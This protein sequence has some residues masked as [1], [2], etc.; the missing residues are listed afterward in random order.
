MKCRS[1]RPTAWLQS[2]C[3]AMIRS[4]VRSVVRSPVRGLFGRFLTPAL[5]QL[6]AY[7]A[8]DAWDFV[9]NSY[10]RAGTV[11]PSGLTVTRASDGYA[12]TASG[13]LVNFGSNVLRRTDRGVLV[14]GA[15]TN[16]LLRS[17]EFDDA[18]WATNDVSKSANQIIA[19]DGTLTGDLVADNSTLTFH[20][21]FQALSFTS[22]D[23]HTFSCFF[24]N[25]T[26]RYVQMAFFI[27]SHGNN[28]FAN[29]DLQAGVVGTVGASASATMT[30]LANGWYRCTIRATATATASGGVIVFFAD[31]TSAARSPSYAG[32][33]LSFYIWGAQLEA[34]PFPSSYIPTA[35]S[36]VTRAADV[37]TAVPTSGTDYPLSLYTEFI[38]SVDTGAFEGVF[39]VDASSRAQRAFISVQPSDQLSVLSRGGANDGDSTVTGVISVGVITKGAGRIEVDNV[40]AVRAGTL[41]TADTTASVPTSPPSAVRFGDAGLAA[42]YGFNY[43]RRAAIIPRA[44]SDTELQAITT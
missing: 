7:G 35:A 21:V 12:E 3:T 41:A 34:A 33:G 29:F 13:T 32:T 40:Q 27:A 25:N 6:S 28:A 44:L 39:Q 23:V 8:R 5:S 16:L 42:N 4:M 14:E 24:K 26:R 10:I 18:V 37:V 15:R 22:G 43:I 17:Q 20:A 31:S 30:A 11:G 2:D 19:P 36:T 38:R 1:A 9:D